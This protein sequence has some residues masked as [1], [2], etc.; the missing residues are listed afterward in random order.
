MRILVVSGLWPPDVGGPASHAPEFADHL[1]S[2]GHE[3]S[4]VTMAD[5]PMAA[6]SYP[7]R[8]ASRRRPPG[9]RHL[10]VTALVARYGRAADVVYMA[11]GL[12]GRTAPGAWIARAP[13]VVKLTDDPAY[14]R[15]R[16][17]GFYSGGLE[18]FQRKASD[19]RIRAL[20]VLRDRALR[21]AVRV[22]CPSDYLRRIALGWGLH[23][24]RVRVIANP[25]PVLPELPPREELRLR[26][27]FTGPTLV[28]AGR[29]AAQKSLE[30]GLDALAQAPAARLI[31]VG[32]GPRRERLAAQATALGLDGR[33]RFLGTR[34][35]R[36]VLELMRAA[37]AALLPSAW[38][39]FPH[40]AVEALAA[41]TP[42]IA[43]R[44]GGVPEIVEDGVNGLLVP[45]RRPDALAAAVRRLLDDRGLAEGLRGR[46]A[47]SVRGLDAGRCYSELETV[48]E[49][50][51]SATRW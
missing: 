16:R 35:R 29:L 1:R 17:L 7:V 9:A 18:A 38:E 24:D 11:G 46:A 31:I 47:E 28:F 34:P 15:A 4:V 21:S 27:G 20:R 5:G 14:E 45:P 36:E 49:E 44:A 6:D 22:V 26:H 40:A 37:D 50:G 39:N 33:V 8:W 51:A 10:A 25:A 12:L 23:P 32:D 41:G 13:L 42:V 19:L 43:S 2:R 3:V 48:L 30:D